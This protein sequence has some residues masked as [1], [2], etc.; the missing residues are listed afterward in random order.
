MF[1]P[2]SIAQLQ[3]AVRWVRDRRLPLLVLGAGTNSL[4][5]DT[6]WEGA[7]ISFHQLRGLEVDARAGTLVAQAGVTNTEIA[8]AA[9]T[10]RLGGAAWMHRLPGQIG[11]T[12]RMNA[13]C[14]GGEIGEIVSTVHTVDRAGVQQVYDLQ[15]SADR[16]AVFRGYK[17]TLFMENGELITQVGLQL[18]PAKDIE[19]ERQWMEHCESDRVGKGQFLYPTCGCVFKNDYRPEVSVSSGFLLERAGVQGMRVGRAEVSPQHSNFVYNKGASSREIL[20]L[21][22]QM[23]ERVFEAFGVWLEYEM[24]ILGTVPADLAPQIYEQRAFVPKAEVLGQLRAEFSKLMSSSRP[25]RSTK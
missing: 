2:T 1:A 8:K 19:A 14:Y 13:R 5:M 23:R 25:A 9:L 22:L 24:E 12:A 3:D 6:R 21:T 15:T 20:E 16:A 10:A 17:D 4:V 11:A 18:S 7:C